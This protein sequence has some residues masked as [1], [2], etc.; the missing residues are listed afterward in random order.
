MMRALLTALSALVCA[1][2]PA[3]ELNV[4]AAS[5]L[6]DALTQIAIAARYHGAEYADHLS[7]NFAASSTLAR[8]I[9]EGAPADV[10][11]SADDRQMDRLQKN[12]HLV[13]ETRRTLLSNSLVVI[14]P[15]DSALNIKSAADLTAVERFAVA[16]PNI[17][18]VGVYTRAYLTRLK[19]WDAIAPK[20]IPVENVRAAVAAV[21]SGNV[22]AGFAYATDARVSKKV[23]VVFAVPADEEPLISYPAAVVK[24]TRDR[25]AAEKFLEF[26]G[27][28]TAT[29]IFETNGFI[30]PGRK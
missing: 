10:F 6:T 26:L 2:A 20:V 3:A 19:L 14:A 15:A 30:V 21:E 27:S 22:D 12:G 7:F 17:V 5:S 13:A 25:Q 18:P 9:E 28:E 24:G 1:S 4:F 16:D 11:F 23:K 8:Q 29:K